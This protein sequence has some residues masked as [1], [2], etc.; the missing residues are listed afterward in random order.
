MLPNTDISGLGVPCVCPQQSLTGSVDSSD[1]ENQNPG[2]ILRPG[3][4][5]DSCDCMSSLHHRQV[6][7][8]TTTVGGCGAAD[9]TPT[10]CL[11]F[12][13][14]VIIDRYYVLFFTAIA[15]SYLRRFGKALR[16][17]RGRLILRGTRPAACYGIRVRAQQW[18]CACSCCSLI[19]GP[20]PLP[21]R[22][23]AMCVCG[24]SHHH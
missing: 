16:P 17:L 4:F 22:L 19:G 11:Q 24:R 2:W 9:R 20:P 12:C 3:S 7:A 5:W 14:P 8:C 15:D 23:D 10:V 1:P 13:T 18:R 6:Q 21:L